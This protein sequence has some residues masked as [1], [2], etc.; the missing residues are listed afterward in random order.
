TIGGV[1]V[2]GGVF[3]VPLNFGLVVFPGYYLEIGA[4]HPGDSSFTIL[5]PRQRIRTAPFATHSA[6]ADSVVSISGQS[7]DNVALATTMVLAG[8]FPSGSSNNYIQNSTTTQAG[9]NFNVSGNGTVGGNLTVT[10]ILNATLPSGSANY[11]QNTTTQQ[12][13]TNFN[14]SGNGT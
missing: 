10:G 12:A 5:S 7:P 6:I 4:K 1:N 2:T 14:V 9:S 11:V 3:T 13:G 8:T